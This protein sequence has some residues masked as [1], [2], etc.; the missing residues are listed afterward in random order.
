MD[1]TILF[2]G[3]ISKVPSKEKV[4]FKFPA[5]SDFFSSITNL[6]PNLGSVSGSRVLIGD[7]ATVQAVPLLNRESPLVQTSAV[8][9]SST[10]EEEIGKNHLSVL[11]DV[12]GKVKRV[13]SDKIEIETDKGELLEKELYNNFSL[14]KKG[15]IHNTP[16]VKAGDPIKPGSLLAT[17][18]YTDDKGTLALGRNLKAA[19][20]P[21]RSNN[22]EDAYAISETGAK[23]LE[24][25]QI[26]TVRVDVQ[27]NYILDKNKYLSVF[28][29]KVPGNLV[30][31]FTPAGV[32]AKGTKVKYG[33]PLILMLAPKTIRSSE[34][35]LGNLSR[36]FKHAFAD[37]AETW[38]YEPEGEVVD[39][40]QTGKVITV[41]V[42][43]KRAVATGD[44]VG[45]L[46]GAK[47]VVRVVPDSEVPVDKDGNPVDIL[48][49]SMSI[50]S[51]VAPAI[52][53]VMQM[54]K[55]AQKRGRPLK[56]QPFIEESS[57]DRTIRHLKKHGIDDQE[58]LY[59]PISGKHI[60]VTTGPLYVHRLTHIAEDKVSTR[61][62]G[63]GY[64]WNEQPSKGG[65]EKA[66]RVGNLATAALLSH[67]AKEVLED[68]GTIRSTKNDEWWNRLKLGL[69]APPPEVPFV[70]E[71][72][73]SSL[74]GAGVKV[75]RDKDVFEV[76]PQTDKDISAISHGEIVS[77]KILYAGKN[78]TIEN[79]PGG[80]FDPTIT[81]SLGE[82][83]NHI[84]LSTKIPNPISEKFVRK[85]TNYSQKQFEEKISTG[86]LA[87]EL[88][89]LDTEQEIKH[90]SKIAKTS[91]GTKK[92]NA[93]EV[94]SFLKMLKNNNMQPKDI[95]LSKVPVIPAKFRPVMV[96]K[97]VVIPADVN[98]LYKDLILV[99]QKAREYK[100]DLP[101]EVKKELNLAQYN[102]TKAIYGLGDPISVKN[103]EKQIKGLLASVLGTQGGTAKSSMFQAN[104]VNKPLD[105]VGRAV[106]VPDVKL[107]LDEA[108]IPQDIIWK[109]YSPF[110][111]RRM[112]RSGIPATLAKQYITDK[113]AI[114]NKYLQEELKDRPGIVSRDPALHKYNL[115]GF[116]LKPNPDP[117]DAT[118]RLNPLVFKSF[119]ADSD[120]DQLGISVPAGDKAKEEIKAKMLPSTNL[121]SA[122]TFTPTYFPTNEAALGLFQA[123]HEDKKNKPIKFETEAEVIKA[124]E[125]G[126]LDIGDRVDVG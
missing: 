63:A 76:L 30:S 75:R 43:T 56:I 14:G 122:R 20:M 2:D 116:Y 10:F 6:I 73:V 18:N 17:S 41:N 60:K 86:E 89:S 46:H 68:I 117:K 13:T 85:L 11:S 113:N 83:Y 12:T 62:E 81:G 23:K 9:H 112:V 7:K 96:D 78:G 39:S 19:I 115:T 32:I 64:T 58:E 99:S 55:V 106:L 31:K 15:F 69:P 109:T 102:A 33:D 123:S 42:K 74:Q 53:T 59:D 5:G 35:Q 16:V 91:T 107:E 36:V 49:N 29:N 25:E 103:K 126:K 90:F 54:G 65:D 47:G 44:K 101:E 105:L 57:V 34:I 82:K 87:K 118:I 77:G 50:T 37:L 70:F 71:K 95:L 4:D 22:F 97:N 66:K 40:S 93:V 38:D 1:K 24:A 48:L 110:V 92:N 94:L 104:V 88:S 21:L 67:N 98:N 124:Y 125:E 84:S 114:A 27:P 121:L 111:I 79:E 51:R 119:N 28:P 52:V 72:F 120:G 8:R 3:K 61:G 80:L 100:E 45:V 26:I 108:S